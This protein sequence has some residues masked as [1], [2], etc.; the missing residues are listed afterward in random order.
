MARRLVWG[1]L[2]LSLCG[3]VL[4][5]LG[6]DAPELDVL[7][8]LR[9]HLAGVFAAS[10]LALWLD[11]RPVLVLAMG[12]FLTLAGHSII[13]QQ[14]QWP[15]IAT[16]QAAANQ[17]DRW[18]ILTLDTWH[19]NP[20]P[21]GLVDYLTTAQADIVVL[22]EFGPNKIALLHE[23][24]ALFPYRADCAADWDC[25]IA[26]L[27]RHPFTSSGTNSESEGTGPARAWLSFGTGKDALTIVG[28]NAAG[29][30]ASP[31]LH[32]LELAQLAS[33]A[34][35]TPGEVLV[36]GSFNTTSWSNAFH[37]FTDRSGLTH[38][39]RFLPSYPS[40][41]LGLPQFAI[42]HV[43]ATSQLSF[44]DV[45]LGPDVASNHRPV[46]ARIKLPRQTLAAL[47]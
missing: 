2:I 15:L 1:A 10:A 33:S 23:L 13:A 3:L 14:R 25:A 41:S 47:R 26:I 5:M 43:F 31:H 12:C 19:R 27:S 20:D 17:N 42:D 34:H 38:M 45:W 8:N 6:R 30:L 36:A 11:H 9:S 35:N 28:V 24:Q 39:G 37:D 16:A 40:G 21:T 46:L 32:A 29:S 4:G 18:T 44:D 7:A 22:T